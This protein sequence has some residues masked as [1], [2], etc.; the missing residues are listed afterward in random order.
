MLFRSFNNTQIQ[1]EWDGRV[2]TRS[3]EELRDKQG[4]VVEQAVAAAPPPAS[5]NSS[6]VIGAGEKKPEVPVSSGE[7]TTQATVQGDTVKFVRPGPFGN[8]TWT[9]SRAELT[10]AEKAMLDG[11]KPASGK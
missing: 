8:Y 11:K 4:S 3:M 9:K 7:P 5:S 6:S 2:V 10:D 1:F